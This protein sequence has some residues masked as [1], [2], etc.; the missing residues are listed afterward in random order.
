MKRYLIVN[1]GSASRKYAFY[2]NEKEIMTAHFEKDDSS[3]GFIVSFKGLKPEI[4]RKIN[5]KEYG[6]SMSIVLDFL[7]EKKL[8]FNTGDISAI[9][10]RIVA[11][12]KY[13]IKVR[14]I[15][16]RYIKKLEEMLEAAPLHIG[17][18]L[19][20]IKKAVKLFPRTMKLGV[21]D[22]A[23]HSTMPE[24][25]STYGLPLITARKFEIHRFG[26]H[27]ISVESVLRKEK[28]MTGRL[29]ARVIVCHLGGGS[30]ATAV[31]NGKSVDT[32]MGFTPL[33]GLWMGTRPGDIGAGALIYLAKKL[34]FSFDELDEY[35]N[36]KSGLLGI[37]GKTSDVRELLKI[38]KNNPRAALALNVFVYRVKKYIGAYMAA[39]GGLDLLIFTA[40][41]GERSDVIRERICQGLEPLGI[42]LDKKKNKRTT[43]SE[44][45]IQSRKSKTKI[46]VIKT[47]ETREIAREIKESKLA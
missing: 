8:I 33:A 43:E 14:P 3:N 40:T 15:D 9:G 46:A 47:D 4:K 10:F 25:A 36:N 41:I 1:P 16:T 34:K 11:P 42:V 22:S 19:S 18:A 38:E 23:F 24:V 21:S 27:G 20:E 39:L 32:S 6:K 37:S 28:K 13:F 31:K 45:F 35:L 44:G 30:S 12:G 29:P 17:P 7:L 5:A 26:Y 2:K